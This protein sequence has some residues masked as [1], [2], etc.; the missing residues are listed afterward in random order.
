[1]SGD[2]WSFLYGAYDTAGFAGLDKIPGALWPQAAAVAL[3]GFSAWSILVPQALASALTVWLVYLAGAHWLGR[4]AGLAAAVGY[5]LTPLVAALAHT[6]VPEPWLALWLV[7]AAY[8]ALR[9]VTAPRRGMWWLAAAGMAI[10]AGFTVKMAEA[11]VLVPAIL[12]PYLVAARPSLTRRLLHAVMAAGATL[13]AS[14]WWVV[15]VWAT[16]AASRPWVG[17]SDTDSPWEMVFGYNGLGRFGLFSGRSFVADFAGPAGWGRLLGDQVS[18]DVMW[19]VPL[20]VAG[21][22]VGLAITARRPR[23]DPERAGY[24]L[25][26]LWLVPSVIVL[27]F[28][29][30]IHTFYVLL[31]AAPAVVLA[32][33]AARQGMRWLA[34]G[35]WWP[36]ALGLVG[37]GAWTLLLV[38][39]VDGPAWVRV[40][41]VAATLGGVLAAWRGRHGIVVT[42]AAVAVLLAPAV[43]TW[44]GLGP[45]DTINPSASATSG[46]RPGAPDIAGRPDP[47]AGGTRP[48]RPADRSGPGQPP[49]GPGARGPGS[50]P[51]TTVADDQLLTWLTER[52]V[53]ATTDL[54]TDSR[55]ASMLILGGLDGVLAMGGGFD[56][57]DP[58][59]TAADLQALVAQ[60]RV[61]YVLLGQEGDRGPARPDGGGSTAGSSVAQARTDW[62]TSTCSVVADAPTASG[63]LYDCA[64]AL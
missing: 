46:A 32:A 49:A 57:S 22:S 21:L 38:A 52:G 16:P 60:G 37:Q 43:W 48:D 45:V 30:G 40:G 63:V 36:L 62:I 11:W 41:V 31:F 50:A 34:A 56:G 26:G 9:A 14:L 44:Q 24:L 10:G 13:L 2:L 18:V 17:G 1:M 42:L 4:P 5:A 28:A 25:F 51:G 19:L 61:Q 35:R 39:R 23:T 53:G 64:S 59:P 12:L 7:L 15:L 58:T 29:E 55:T 20:A 54:A 47:S 33:A 8:L 3:A 27:A 6:N